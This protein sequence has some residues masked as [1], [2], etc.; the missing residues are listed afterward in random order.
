MSSAE[1]K[2][3]ASKGKGKG[4]PKG[5]RKGRE[6]YIRKR[7]KLNFKTQT[8]SRR[9]ARSKGPWKGVFR[10]P[11]KLYLRGVMMG[12]RRSR[13]NQ[14]F[15]RSLIK[16][17]DVKSKEDAKYYLGH[18]V[19]Y[20]YRAVSKK[21]PRTGKSVLRVIPGKIT[22][23]HGNNGTVRVRFSPNLPTRA[24]GKRVRVMMWPHRAP[25]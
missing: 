17:E 10:D 8:E 21:D 6:Q 15:N 13:L 11:V 24:F 4:G 5:G 12:Y 9:E 3:D 14:H 1:Q 25:N 19:L 20:I 18:K 23:T 2:K 22:S 7:Q 16:I